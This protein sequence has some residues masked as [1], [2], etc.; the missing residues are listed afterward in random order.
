MRHNR[1]K[2]KIREERNPP[3]T[4]VIIIIKNEN[5]E[6]STVM[7]NIIVIVIVVFQVLGFFVRA[8][9]RPASIQYC[10]IHTVV[11]IRGGTYHGIPSTA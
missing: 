3:H 7:T 8:R 10:N 11:T 1:S 6:R 5:M 9:K 2:G 4:Y